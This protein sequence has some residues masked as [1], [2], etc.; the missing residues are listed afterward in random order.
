MES[1]TPITTNTL[2]TTTAHMAGVSR[3]T[4]AQVARRLGVRRACQA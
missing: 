1:S 3:A 2:S 4:L